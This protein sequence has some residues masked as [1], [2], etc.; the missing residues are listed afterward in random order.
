[1]PANGGPPSAVLSGNF[2]FQCALRAKR[3]VLSE[4]RDGQSYFFELDPITGRG[5]LL[6]KVES[7]ISPDA[8]D[9]S[10]DGNFISFLPKG[11][12]S[13]DGFLI[14]IVSL[15]DNSLRSIERKNESIVAMIWA[16]DSRYFYC[17]VT[18]R[19]SYV[20]LRIDLQGNSEVLRKGAFGPDVPLRLSPSPDGRFLT[21]TLSTL[22][23]NAVLLENF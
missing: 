19:E 5:P 7:L 10:A 6:A 2:L 15:Q 21:Y 9:L 18:Q 20:L 12:N 23:S 1:M 22:D 3:C 14:R 8:W 11:K 13:F 4:F 17:V 16:A